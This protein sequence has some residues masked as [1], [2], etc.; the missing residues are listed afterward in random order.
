[1]KRAAAQTLALAAAALCAGCGN[2]YF[3]DWPPSYR[4]ESIRVGEARDAVGP[5]A[6]ALAGAGAASVYGAEAVVNNPA[7]LVNLA[8]PALGGGFGYCSTALAVQPTRDDIIAQGFF[9]SFAPAYGAAAYAPK[10]RRYAVGAAYW[11]PYDYTYRLGSAPYDML[12]SRGALRAASGAAAASALGFQWGAAGDFLWGRQRMTSSRASFAAVDAPARGYDVR[13]AIRR[14]VELRPGWTLA[15]AALGRKGAAVRFAGTEG[16]DVAFPPAVGG[17]VSVRAHSI[18]VHI[19]YRYTFYG[20]LDASDAALAQVMRAVAKDAGEAMG[21]AEY[22]L[23]SGAIVRGGVAYRP[24]YIANATGHRVVGVYYAMG[25]GWPTLE[26]R[27][28]LEAALT[29]G[30]R[31]ALDAEG[32]AADLAAFELGFNYFW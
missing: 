12:E 31:G 16:Y 11:T 15:A 14:E 7:A 3:D 2:S 18:N 28:R 1:M 27:A 6:T 25:A 19:D 32:Y 29:Y 8:G 10:S 23:S 5:R 20:A 13:A 30:R 21:G 26:R 17:A 4:Q 9:G 24:W 22:V